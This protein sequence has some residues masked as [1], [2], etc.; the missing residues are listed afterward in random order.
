MMICFP[1]FK[2]D[3]FSWYVNV[4]FVFPD[5]NVTG[6][7]NHDINIPGKQISHLH[8]ENKS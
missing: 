1:V 4:I 6:K 5:I 8:R 2:Y 7:T 3:L